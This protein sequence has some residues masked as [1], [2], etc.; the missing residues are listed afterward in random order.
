[1]TITP[2]SR[3]A[4]LDLS[5]QAHTALVADNIVFVGDLLQKDRAEVD[6]AVVA[7]IE[8]ALAPHGLSLGTNDPSWP[9]QNIEAAL[10]A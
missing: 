10:A 6:P 5:F 9:P 8:A 4:S 7:E 1:M 3:T 2:L